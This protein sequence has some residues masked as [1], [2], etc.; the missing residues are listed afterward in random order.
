M[1][2]KKVK[3]TE[4]VAFRVEADMKRSIEQIATD[5]VATSSDVIRHAIDNLIKSV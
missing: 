5:N 2:P 1:I 4:F 3:K